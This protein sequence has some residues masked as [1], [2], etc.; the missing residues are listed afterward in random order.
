MVVPVG[1]VG[2]EGNGFTIILNVSEAEL[3]PQLFTPFKEIF[4]VPLKDAF[5][6]TLAVV[7]VPVILPAV[8]GV[9]LHK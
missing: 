1:V 9:I 3:F 7:V 5:Q 8:E 2:F 4:A 6:L